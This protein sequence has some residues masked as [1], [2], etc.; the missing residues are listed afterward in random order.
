VY[1][2]GQ[3]TYYKIAAEKDAAML[4]QAGTIGRKIIQQ[5]IDFGMPII[6]LTLCC[7][8]CIKARRQP[9]VDV[10]MLARAT[11]LSR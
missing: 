7:A 9:F 1:I 4:E 6:F 2:T 11:G 10:R 3:R 5:I 8:L